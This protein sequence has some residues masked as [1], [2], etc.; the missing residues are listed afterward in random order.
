MWFQ[1]LTL[2][3]RSISGSYW[4]KQDTSTPLQGVLPREWI[5]KGIGHTGIMSYYE[6][7]VPCKAKCFL[8]REDGQEVI[9]DSMFPPACS[10]RRPLGLSV[11]TSG[12][13]QTGWNW[14]DYLERTKVRQELL[15]PNKLPTRDLRVINLAVACKLAPC[16]SGFVTEMRENGNSTR[17]H[18]C[19][20]LICKIST[21]RKRL[22]SVIPLI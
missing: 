16:L 1:A 2:P 11:W 5:Q 6:V 10:P 18:S 13:T 19:V 14:E 12:L 4:H 8:Y 17:L 22:I 15:H 9:F 21:E 20:Y 7:F 3:F